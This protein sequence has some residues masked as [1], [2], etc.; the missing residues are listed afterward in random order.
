MR[1]SDNSSDSWKSDNFNKGLKQNRLRVITLQGAIENSPIYAIL[2]NI[3]NEITPLLLISNLRGF[4][5]IFAVESYLLY[6]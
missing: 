5:N 3:N 4:N 2:E 1:K 6:F